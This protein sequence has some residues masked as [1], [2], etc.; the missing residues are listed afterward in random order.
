MNWLVLILSLPSENATARTRLWRAQRATGAAALRD[1]VWLLPD[2][3]DLEAGLSSQ[4]EDVRNA[5][6]SAW[7]LRVRGDASQDAAFM[8]LFGRDAD[9]A[10]LASSLNALDPAGEL[11]S[12][13]RGL[14]Q[15]RKRFE[16]LSQIDF[17]PGPGRGALESN[18]HRLE[19]HLRER[20]R[21]GEPG[22]A[23]GV[24]E[25]LDPANFQGHLWATRRNLWVDRLASA[26]LI[27]RFIDRRARFLWLADASACPA[28]AH[29]FDFDGARFTHL[30]RRVTFETLLATF[31]LEGH[32]ALMRLGRVIHALDAAGNAPEAAGLE[33]LLKGIKARAPEDDDFLEAGGR[34]LDDLHAAFAASSAGEAAT[35]TF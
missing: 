31:G 9:Y 35:Q 29:G 28:D 18:L 1:G 25:S 3:P 34:L 20:L 21:H 4:V 12:L 22:F 2:R 14:R 13:R 6:G 33:M 5:A 16:A 24:P 10:E 8:A 27:R 11:E 17:F 32:P 26:W 7:V 30:G 23:A 15:A 19:V